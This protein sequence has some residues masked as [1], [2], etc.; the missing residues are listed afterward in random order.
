MMPNLHINHP[1][2]DCGRL[3]LLREAIQKNDWFYICLSQM[4]S[5][6]QTPDLLPGSATPQLLHA[7]TYLDML[8]CEN[9]KVNPRV[10]QWLSQFPSEIRS[11]YSSPARSVYDDLVREVVQFV[12]RMTM[13]WEQLVHDCRTRGA[14]P[15]MD[16]LLDV[17]ALRS[18]VL[19]TT[20]FRAI[21]RMIKEVSDPLE[22]LHRLDQEAF[23]RG[24]K[25]R[26]PSEK[27]AAYNAFRITVQRLVDH[28]Q[29]SKNPRISH[30][31]PFTIPPIALTVFRVGI[32][33]PTP[34]HARQMQ[35]PPINHFDS[36]QHQQPSHLNTQVMSHQRHPS[37]GVSRSPPQPGTPTTPVIMAYGNIPLPKQQHA[38]SRRLVFPHES[39]QPRAQ[40]THPDTLRSAL[41]QAHLRS[42]TLTPNKLG[43]PRLY[44]YV[45]SFALAPRKINKELVVETLS[46]DIPQYTYDALPPTVHSE[47]PG[48]RPSCTLTEQSH[49]I[50]LR[51]AT[52][53]G[54]ALKSESAWME[55][56]NYWPD[57]LYLKFNGHMLEQR[58]KL[59]HNRYLP[60][61]LTAIVKPGRNDLEVVVNRMST[62]TRPYEYALAVEIVG[63]IG[64]N[65]ICRD[66]KHI[67]SADSLASI[68]DSLA[69]SDDDDEI[70]I[71]SS[72]ATIQLF[73]PHTLTSIFQ[74]P[75]RGAACLHKDCFDLVTFL[76]QREPKNT[77]GTPSVVDCWRCPICR[78]DVRPHTL[79]RDGFMDTVRAELEKKGM[80]DTRAIL[81]EPDGSWK[82]KA[83]E[84]GGVRSPSLDREEGGG[85]ARSPVKQ[86]AKV[87]EVIEID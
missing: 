21:A 23:A 65:A 13:H 70:A 24:R 62:D 66:I 61:D 68:K 9:Y 53:T 77:P 55:A 71:T 86:T 37:T 2:V 33:A 82:P 8:L 22:Q 31:A 38:P 14:P 72:T 64:H 42:P 19:Q 46:F 87:V 18:P 47:E 30:P 36:T 44:R 29:R 54:K 11:I 49:A 1:H 16:D 12:Q 26:T 52:A 43:S 59:H 25:R 58:R 3:S 15:L 6:A 17:L 84:T 75:A 5:L 80:L 60:I 50:R 81:V 28:E 32:P 73:D 35:G 41:H 40:P 85:N 39:E 57:N 48:G 83:E 20:V 78:G 4:H 63:L 34:L 10:L 69:A 74:V 45:A 79:V 56:D 27:E 7:I 67:S 51:C 76:S